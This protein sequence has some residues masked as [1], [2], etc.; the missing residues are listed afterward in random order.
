MKQSNWESLGIT[1]STLGFGCMRFPKD[2]EG[3]ID[4]EKATAMLE[5]ARAA[6]VTY[7]DT[8]WPYHGGESE[9]FLGSV[10]KNW[11][12]DSFY[13]ATKL[14]VWLT[15]SVEKAEEIFAQQLEH[16]QTDHIDFFLL[17]AL[18][19]KRFDKIVAD[20]I[21]DWA[22]AQKKAGKVVHLGFSFHDDYPAFGRMLKAYPWD[23]CQ[24]QYNYMDV[25]TQAGDRGYE[26]AEKLG[27][28]M[29]IMEPIKGGTLAALP[30]AAAAPL[31]ALRPD[32]S[33][34]SW[35]LRWVAKHPN[36]KVILSGMSTPE[37]VE[38]NLN[39]FAHYEELTE[40]EEAA[41]AEAR[42]I[43][44]ARVRNGC[45]GCR[46][47]MPCPAGVDIPGNFSVWNNY[48]M[49]QNAAM[50]KAAWK[51]HLDEGEK[52]KNC[53]KCGKCEAACPQHLPIRANLET[54]Q[55]EL[56]NL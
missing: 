10:I 27:I 18:D 1:T 45:T 6:G 25:D 36:C 38:D 26:L 4:R 55:A 37:Q 41:V 17:H 28:P 31:R 13:V 32:A 42:S 54:L 24:I 40:A 56:D 9:P 22:F 33:D 16:L 29:V 47:C 49:Y 46:Y 21:V 3:K 5:A 2:A 50:A 43:L 34:A 20:G 52:A 7:F 14:P 30:D 15:D 51:N 19:G 48:G 44:K 53:V 8:A 23:F 11:P 12:R 35:A 39:T